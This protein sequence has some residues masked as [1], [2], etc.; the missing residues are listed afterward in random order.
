MAIPKTVNIR[1]LMGLLDW[2]T[3]KA[4]AFYTFVG[5]LA[6][7]AWHNGLN[8]WNLAGFVLAAGLGSLSGLAAIIHG[9]EPPHPPG[10]A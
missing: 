7:D 6:S 1:P 3:K 10:G 5:M 2:K 8:R 4:T 9:N